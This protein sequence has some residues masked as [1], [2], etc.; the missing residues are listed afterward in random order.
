[1]VTQPVHEIKDGRLSIPYIEL[2]GQEVIG[3]PYCR[4][5]LV[6]RFKKAM[7]PKC[8]QARIEEVQLDGEI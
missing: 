3:D 7:C 1:M 4:Y 8:L 2:D 6:D 5:P